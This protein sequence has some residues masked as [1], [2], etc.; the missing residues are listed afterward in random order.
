MWIHCTTHLQ[1]KPMFP[2]VPVQASRQINVPE[3]SQARASLLP[4][5]QGPSSQKSQRLRIPLSIPLPSDAQ[6]LSSTTAHAQPSIQ[7][8][9]AEC[10]SEGARRTGERVK[11]PSWP[12]Q[13]STRVFCLYQRANTPHFFPFYLILEK[14]F[15]HYCKIRTDVA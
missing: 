4:P 13:F 10:P 1:S 12:L 7:H 9:A 6:Q 5:F 11:T 8:R 3:T 15:I 2:P 14:N